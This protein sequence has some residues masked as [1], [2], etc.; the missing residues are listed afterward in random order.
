[1]TVANQPFNAEVHI[2]PGEHAMPMAHRVT[3]AGYE[4]E[5][6]QHGDTQR[7]RGVPRDGSLWRRPHRKAQY[8]HGVTPGGGPWGGDAA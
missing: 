1:M 3:E 2:L 4:V 8:G 7:L 6:Y 5:L